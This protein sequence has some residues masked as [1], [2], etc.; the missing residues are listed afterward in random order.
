M[1]CCPALPIR[2]SIS[3]QLHPGHQQVYDQHPGRVHSSPS[4]GSGNNLR[5]VSTI[6][7]IARIYDYRPCS[8]VPRY[9]YAFPFRRNYIQAITR[10]VACVLEERSHR[11]DQVQDIIIVAWRESALQLEYG[12]ID[13]VVLS[14][15]SNTHFHFVAT[16]SRP[17]LEL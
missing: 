14:N 15:I 1:L 8:A 7:K 5:Y 4:R 10:A 17:L 12:I 11:Q 9:Q 3:S 6:G 2:I 16:I 13:L